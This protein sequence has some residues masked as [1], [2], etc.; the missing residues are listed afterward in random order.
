[1]LFKGLDYVV[2][3]RDTTDNKYTF[4]TLKTNGDTSSG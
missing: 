3:L 2:L 1:M 4:D